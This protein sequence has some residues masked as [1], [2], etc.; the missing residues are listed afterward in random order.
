MLL[1][2]NE[3]LYLKTGVHP[4]DVNQNRGGGRWRPH[5]AGF[6]G[7]GAGGGAVGGGAG[8]RIIGGVSLVRDYPGRH[9]SRRRSSL[10]AKGIVSLSGQCEISA[11]GL[12]LL[13]E[14]WAM[15]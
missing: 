3:V 4:G 5:P 11:W 7:P 1:E 9:N 15:V 10:V 12:S 6:H 14:E 13:K 2:L 8:A